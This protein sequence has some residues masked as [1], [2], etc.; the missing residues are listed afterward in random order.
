MAVGSGTEDGVVAGVGVVVE[1]CVVSGALLV[2]GSLDDIKVVLNDLCT[3]VY[4]IMSHNLLESVG[5][6]GT[7]SLEA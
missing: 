1:T 6:V 5:F 7:L 3:E 4:A 2:V